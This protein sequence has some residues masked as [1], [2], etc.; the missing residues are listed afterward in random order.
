MSR[1]PHD[2]LIGHDLADN[3]RGVLADPNR[4]YSTERLIAEAERSNSP[5]LAEW[6]RAEELARES[7]AEPTSAKA[8]AKRAAA[9]ADGIDTTPTA[10]RSKKTADAADKTPRA[11]RGDKP[12]PDAA[13]ERAA[14]ESVIDDSLDDQLAP[15]PTDDK[16]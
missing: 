13:A 12:A 8:G 5:Q 15:A 7:A 1:Q 3:Y 9:N 6:A 4:N 11:R 16:K 10:A 14:A 2:D